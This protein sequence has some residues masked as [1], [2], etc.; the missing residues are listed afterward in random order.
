[1]HFRHAGKEPSHLKRRRR[2]VWHYF[3]E[4]VVVGLKM[5]EDTSSCGLDAAPGLLLDIL[6]SPQEGREGLCDSPKAP[7][8][9]MGGHDANP[10]RLL[11]FF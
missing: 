10:R 2:Y 6:R 1:M 4:V 8:G 11:V 7:V 5:L 3:V 9:F